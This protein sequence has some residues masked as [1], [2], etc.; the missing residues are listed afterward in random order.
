MAWSTLNSKV[1]AADVPGLRAE[2]PVVVLHFGASWNRLDQ[3]MDRRL[4]D[5]ARSWTGRAFVGAVDTDDPRNFDFA[6]RLGVLGLPT[7]AL[8][9]KGGSWRTI[10]AAASKRE[11]CTL[12]DQ[13]IHHGSEVLDARPEPPVGK[14]LRRTWE[15][16]KGPRTRTGVKLRP[17]ATEE[18][19]SRF[20][21]KYGVILPRDMREY[22]AV[23]DGME[24]D[25]SEGEFLFSFW[26]L[27]RVQPISEEFRYTPPRATETDGRPPRP[28]SYFC[29]A[30]YMIEAEVFAIRLSADPRA[31]NPVIGYDGTEKATS[32]SD[33]VRKYLQDARQLM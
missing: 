29:F 27:G 10:V 23:V 13:A 14:L 6:R 19:I 4:H 22:F 16:R 18:E 17:P 5:L 20:E 33:F 21:G 31:T 7:L 12:L 1:T 2:Y 11:L 3:T 28:E 9:I 24:R 32:F 30:D 8:T 25:S 15:A 26:E